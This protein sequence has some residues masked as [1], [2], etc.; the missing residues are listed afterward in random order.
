MR[1]CRLQKTG[2]QQVAWIDVE[3]NDL[4]KFTSLKINGSEDKGWQIISVGHIFKTKE[5]VAT[6]SQEHKHLPSIN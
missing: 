2:V 1:Q 6:R 4:S 5:E 3:H